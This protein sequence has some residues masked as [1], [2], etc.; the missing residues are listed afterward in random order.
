MCVCVCVLARFAVLII[1][2]KYITSVIS[3][4]A[5]QALWEFTD[6]ETTLNWWH[7]N[8]GSDSLPIEPEDE[9]AISFM[10]LGLTM[11]RVSH[12]NNESTGAAYLLIL[13]LRLATLDLWSSLC[14]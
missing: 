5:F 10:L 14:I 8:C 9:C 12:V 3:A 11:F 6:T 2:L 1:S 4:A 13:L 7:N